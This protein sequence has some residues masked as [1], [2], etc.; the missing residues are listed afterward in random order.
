M[1][2][3]QSEKVQGKDKEFVRYSLKKSF[4]KGG[5]EKE[6][7]IYF[8]KREILELFDIISREA[9]FLKKEMV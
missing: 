4:N 2:T 9:A 1:I 5:E 7:Y 6:R 3:L 8:T